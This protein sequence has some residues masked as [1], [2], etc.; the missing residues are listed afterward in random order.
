MT[1]TVSL[2]GYVDFDDKIRILDQ[3]VSGFKKVTS[4]VLTA[5]IKKNVFIHLKND[6]LIQF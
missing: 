5:D 4:K 3:N 2:N 1:S 6:H